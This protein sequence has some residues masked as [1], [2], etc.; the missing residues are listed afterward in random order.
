MASREIT[1]FDGTR[2]VRVDRYQRVVKVLLEQKTK[3]S[4]WAH[5]SAHAHCLTFRLTMSGGRNR[6]LALLLL[7]IMKLTTKRA[8]WSDVW[9][10]TD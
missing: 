3:V 2:L 1:L 5:A 8:K 6:P 4:S 9:E 7:R 10:W